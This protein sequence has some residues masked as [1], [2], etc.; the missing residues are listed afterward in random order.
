MTAMTPARKLAAAVVGGGILVTS[1]L[2]VPTASAVGLTC[3][4][5]GAG[6]DGLW[7]NA[8]NWAN[9]ADAAPGEGD[10]LR[11]GPGAATLTTT[12]DLAGVS[13]EDVEFAI[14]GYSV[15]GSQL[16]TNGL[17]V[18]G[19]TSLEVNVIL[20]VAAGETAYQISAP[21]TVPI[22]WEIEFDQEP[23]TVAALQLS[24]G[25]V[26]DA[27]LDGAGDR[28]K[29]G[30]DG[31][32]QARG[33]SYP[34]A[35]ELS[36]NARVRCGGIE[37]GIAGGQVTITDAAGLEFTA[38]TAFARSIQIGPG[39]AYAVDAAGHAVD[40]EG[41]VSLAGSAA[42]RGGQ[43]SAPMLFSGGVA[44][45][46]HHLTVHGAT[47][48]PLFANLTSTAAGG[49][50]VGSAD[51]PGSIHIEEGQL[52]HNGSTAASGPG[53]LIVAD[54]AF[55]LGPD[56][57]P[58]TTL[59]GGATLGTDSVITL[60]EEVELIDGSAVAALSSGAS[61][62]LA[63]ASFSGGANIQTRASSSSLVIQQLSSSDGSTLVL[64]SAG[65]DAPIIFSADGLSDYTGV[66]VATSG[67]VQ[68]DR[69]LSIPG[70]FRIVDAAVTTLHTLPDDLH[71]L[72]ADTSAVTIDGAGS[73]VINDNERIASLAGPSGVVHVVHP[74]SGL[75]VEGSATTAYAG[76]FMGPGHLAHE[77]AGTLHL[78]GDWTQAAL[79]STLDA[80]GGTVIVDGSMPFT[81]A[82]VFG[83]LAGAGVLGE[84]V[85]DAGTVAPGTSPG[86]LTVEGAVSGSGTIAVELGGAEP[87]DAHDQILSQTQDLATVTWSVAL[88]DGFQPAVGDEFVVLSTANGGPAL[89]A[90]QATAGDTV[91][92]VVWD[93]SDV[94]LRTAE[95]PVDPPVEPPVNPP[96]PGENPVQPDNL[97]VTGADS[98]W[99]SWITV[100]GALAA[101]GA[102]LA[103]R[104]RV[105]RHG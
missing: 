15:S 48:I 41:P 24:D 84:V 30:G 90:A 81:T 9:C 70:D 34:G 42:V 69:E 63:N 83:T 76:D 86:C 92:D 89:P 99:V 49:L 54:D 73:L 21:L 46:D 57:L 8:A 88:T 97:A 58:G 87:C 77:G 51:I 105:R 18:A 100:A 43:D 16:R 103:L 104:A 3:D 10:L 75:T 61:L 98:S 80:E 67:S 47:A 32:V 25:A 2:A 13:F 55:A 22:P 27:R 14:D 78:T 29:V 40:L 17:T 5:T 12:N 35:L 20:P 39:T 52:D 44:L 74:D 19:S 82:E 72:I 95:V 85:I 65:A 102:V 33:L 68:L 56:A 7:S 59:E 101:A 37:C 1:L 31:V 94:I 64:G 4:W 66:T 79:G 26:V 6:A 28:L 53:S 93:G 50:Q 91:F 45:A 71:N 38:D 96:A 36:G 23:L 11:F 62:T 60:S